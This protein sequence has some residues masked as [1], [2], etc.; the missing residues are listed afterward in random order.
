MSVRVYAESFSEPLADRLRKPA[1]RDLRLYWLGQ[2]GFV[3][4][5]AGLRLVVDPYL[6]DTLAAKYANTPFPHTRMAPPP[7]DPAGLGA[8][9][10]VLCTHHHTDHMDPGTLGPLARRRPTLRFLVPTASLALASERVAEVSS[11]LTGLDAG[12][13][14][15]LGADVSIRAVRAAHETLERDSEGR[16]RFL[17]YVISAAGR[18]IYHSGDCIPFDGLADEIAEL[19]PDLALLPVNG[20][21]NALRQAGFAGNFTIPEGIGLC[22]SAGIP[23]LICHHYGM[24][25]FNTVEPAAIDDA[26]AAAPLHAERARFQVAY[27]L[28]AEK[29]RPAPSHS[30]VKT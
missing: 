10:F 21:S 14:F 3:I 18:R 25:A 27:G 9:D 16:H 5:G 17:G 28:T 26:T 24:F 23:N 20:R 4:E 22:I 7:L 19:R 13:E 15:V 6:S 11:L 8:V 30:G 12:D 2:A 1:S 29:H